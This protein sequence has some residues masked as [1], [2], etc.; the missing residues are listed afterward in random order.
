M[1][2]RHISDFGTLMQADARAQW[3]ESGTYRQLPRRPFWRLHGLQIF[4]RHFSYSHPQFSETSEL[5]LRHSVQPLTNN[6]NLPKHYGLMLHDWSQLHNLRSRLSHPSTN[7][8]RELCH[9]RVSPKFNPEGGL[10]SNTA[11]CEFPRQRTRRSF[12]TLRSQFCYFFLPIPP[13]NLDASPQHTAYAIITIRS[14][15]R[16]YSLVTIPR[17]FLRL[18]VRG[19]IRQRNES[20]RK[21]Q[22]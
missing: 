6:L 7:R 11:L 17:R 12:A 9:P 21:S 3:A 20:F 8:E 22:S 1:H 19:S 18:T 14:L 10:C 4:K 5:A 15:S 13:P 2:G 16:W